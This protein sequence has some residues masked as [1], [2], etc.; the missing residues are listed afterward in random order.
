MTFE[1]IGKGKFSATDPLLQALEVLEPF[2]GEHFVN[3][4]FR[5]EKGIQRA[6]D[7]NLIG[8]GLVDLVIASRLYQVKDIFNPPSNQARCF[9]LMRHPV[10]RAVS[11]FYYLKQAAH[12]RSYNK[13]MAHM[14]IE[15]Y[16]DSKKAESNWMTRSLTPGKLQGGVLNDEDLYKAMKFLRTKCVIGLTS[17][18]SVSYRRFEAYFELKPV[19]EAGCENKIMSELA[20][21]TKP[22]PDVKEG[23]SVWRAFEDLNS[24]DMKLYNYAVQLFQEQGKFFE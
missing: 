8:S 13:E 19:K 16:L 17:Q 6:I 10:D 21:T 18:F 24:F 14:T 7:L 23:S 22:H 15:E 9:T 1:N 20:L 11:L 4:E 2:P 5:T 12:E 3:V